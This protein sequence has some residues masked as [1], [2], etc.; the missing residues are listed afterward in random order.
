[1]LPSAF[2]TNLLRAPLQVGQSRTLNTKA[3]IE[4][5]GHYLLKP[6]RRSLYGG[7]TFSQNCC[8]PLTPDQD[9]G[10]TKG[11]DSPR[12]AEEPPK[13]G[14]GGERALWSRGTAGPSAC[15]LW[16]RRWAGAQQGTL[17]TSLL[18]SCCCTFQLRSPN[19]AKPASAPATSAAAAPHLHLCF[20]RF[21]RLK[22]HT[23]LPAHVSAPLCA[24]SR[25]DSC[26]TTS[27][28]PV[29]CQVLVVHFHLGVQENERQ[30]Y[31]GAPKPH[32]PR[33][34]C[35][36]AGG[37]NKGGCGGGSITSCG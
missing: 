28:F 6:Q 26:N 8:K 31:K 32:T 17:A 7:L 4:E 11:A 12:R 3:T 13:Q 15:S 9:W 2:L 36:R 23:S 24:V 29:F 33:C 14:A 35:G 5:T 34:A 10:L 21:C 30:L 37:E 16:A 27:C 20:P 22:V 19:A 1:M 18:W 25:A